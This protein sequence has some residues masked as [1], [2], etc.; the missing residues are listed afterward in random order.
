MKIYV[1]NS[2][3]SALMTNEGLQVG[4]KVF[5]MTHGLSRNGEYYLAGLYS[6][7][8]DRDDFSILACTG[9]PS[10]PHTILEFGQDTSTG[11]T[12]YLRTDK[13]YGPSESYFKMLETKEIS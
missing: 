2:T 4:D 8:G 13:G 12:P 10:E 1:R 7:D 6:W 9:F 5:P 11:G 3:V